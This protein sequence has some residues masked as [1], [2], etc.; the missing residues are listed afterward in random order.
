MRVLYRTI[1]IDLAPNL[2]VKKL[3]CKDCGE[4]KKTEERVDVVSIWGEEETYCLECW[5]KRIWGI[6]KTEDRVYY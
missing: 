4:I 5:Y 2:Y 3:R 6:D 1:F